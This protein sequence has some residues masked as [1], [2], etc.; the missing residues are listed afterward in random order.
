MDI[1]DL[2]P[3]LECVKNGDPFLTEIVKA[4]DV[5][6]DHHWNDDP[7]AQRVVLW[8]ER[9]RMDYELDLLERWYRW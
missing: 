5:I 9:M 4:D 6:D 3:E 1:H 2:F 8:A 7:E